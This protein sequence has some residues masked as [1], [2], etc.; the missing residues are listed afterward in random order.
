MFLFR[1]STCL[2][3]FAI[4]PVRSFAINPVRS[5]ASNAVRSFTVKSPPT[6]EALSRLHNQPRHYAIVEVTE[7]PHYVTVG[8]TIV[9]LRRNDLNLGDKIILDRIREVGSKDYILQGN[10]YV[11]PEYVRV[12]GTVI[13]HPESATF[14][15]ERKRRRQDKTVREHTV[16]Y[17][18]IRVSD[19]QILYN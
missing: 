16:P 4:N 12:T 3:S 8:D 7:S 6:K 2:R 11:R 13:G 15:T 9:S 17:T 5:F 10:P 1:A 18:L 19:I 14:V